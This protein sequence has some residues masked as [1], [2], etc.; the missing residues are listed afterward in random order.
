MEGIG[1]GCAIPARNPQCGQRRQQPLN[2]RA[3][4]RAGIEEENEA[5]S[6][7]K[8]GLHPVIPFRLRSTE[9]R[10]ISAIW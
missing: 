7:R 10:H 9:C 8:G 4:G 2:A 5:E 6:G 3:A 1:N